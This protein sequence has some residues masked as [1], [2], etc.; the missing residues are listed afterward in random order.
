MNATSET[1]FD[2]IY[3]ASKSPA[4]LS[5]VQSIQNAPASQSIRLGIAET[6]AN[7]L[8]AAGHTA[9]SE[10]V[11]NPIMV[12]GWGPFFVMQSLLTQGKTTTPDGTGKYAIKVSLDP[13]DYPPYVPPP[14]HIVPMTTQE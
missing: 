10:L 12:W 11:D 14:A 5:M 8:A 2:P 4:I 1:E 6:V 7:A 3:W 13:S 9:Q